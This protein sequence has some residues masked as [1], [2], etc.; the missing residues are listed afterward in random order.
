MTFT[1]T[2]S[3]A[4]A[5]GTVQFTIDG[6]SA[7][8]VPLIAGQATYTTAA[9]AVGGHLVGADYSGDAA[10]LPAPA[11]ISPRRVGPA[12]RATTTV[13]TSNRNPSSTFGQNVTFTATVRPV[14]GTGIPTGTVQFTIDGTDVGGAVTLNAQGR[15]TYS[16]A[17]LLGRQPH[18]HRRL[19]WIGDLRWRRQRDLRPARQPGATTTRRDQQPQ[20]V[21]LRADASPSP[22]G[23]PRRRRPAR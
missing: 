4:S 19:Q 9:L 11:R 1:A 18:R 10:Y 7:A 15:A 17:G 12:L 23:S 13:V 21:R 14:T 3:P 20:P 5:T 16:T 8:T 2:V 22:P 6:T